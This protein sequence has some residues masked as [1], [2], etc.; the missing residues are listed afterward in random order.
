[1]TKN[2][3][4]FLVSTPVAGRSF[5]ALAAACLISL[6]ASAAE[7]GLASVDTGRPTRFDGGFFHGR[8]ANG[9]RFN[10]YAMA[11]AHRTLPLGTIVSVTNKRS[12][13]S[14][15]VRIVDRGPCGTAYCQRR[16]PDLLK[17]IIDLTPESADAIHLHGLGPVIVRVCKK[18]SILIDG[19]KIRTLS[20]S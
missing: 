17:R 10:P 5:F 14:A 12:G 13:E 16:R 9:Q 20:C 6:Q 3:K 2:Q 4:R 7:F 11:A 19:I 15:Y 18:Y 8:L 1:M